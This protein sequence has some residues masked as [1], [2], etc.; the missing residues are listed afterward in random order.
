MP[1]YTPV[2]A[3]LAAALL[4]PTTAHAWGLVVPHPTR[5]GEPR[6]IDVTSDRVD[7]TVREGGTHQTHRQLD[8]MIGGAFFD[9][10]GEPVPVTLLV[11]DV[12]ATH[13]V[14][15]VTLDGAPIV[16]TPLDATELTAR[17]L[18]LAATRPTPA[19]AA[20]AGMPGHVADLTLAPGPHT[21]T[22]DATPAVAHD[23]AMLH[24]VV[25]LRDLDTACYTPSIDVHMTLVTRAPVATVFTPFHDRT[26]SRIEPGHVETTVR[27]SS[28]AQC[29]DLHAFVVSGDAAIESALLSYRAP[30]CD[31]AADDGTPGY[32]LI[33]GGTTVAEASDDTVAKD[34][35]LVIDTSGSMEGEKI[36]Q[37]RAA[38]LSILDHLGP[39]DRYDLVTFAGE[40][41]PFF[42]G[43]RDASDA[44]SLD[45]ARD[46][47]RGLTAE[48]STNIHDALLTALAGLG[49]GDTE[50]P[51]MLL[52]LTDGAATA[53]VTDSDQI[54]AAVD[55]ANEAG[56]RFHTF[57][58]GYGVNTYL[59]DE[60]AR[61]NDG[62]AHYITPGVDIEAALAAFYARVRAPVATHLRLGA[63]GVT[64]GDLLPADLPDLFVDG[65][66]LALGRYGDAAAAR[67]TID[68]DTRR[69]PRQFPVRGQFVRRGTA[70][71]FLPRLWASRL[72]GELLYAARQN[73]GDDVM[74]AQIR[75]LAER[76]GF[77]T[78]WT[79]FAVDEAGNVDHDYSNPTA[80]VSGSNAVHTSAGI[81][82]IAGNSNAGAYS[83]SGPGMA[84]MKNV[85]DRTFVRRAGYWHDTTVPAGIHDADEG[86]LD[87][88]FMDAQW[89]ALVAAA[90]ELREFLA[91][92]RN[93]VVAWQCLV[94][95]VTDP[96]SIDLDADELPAV[97]V[98]P[99][100]FLAG[101]AS[102]DVE[103]IPLPVTPGPIVPI[104]GDDATPWRPVD[105]VR[106]DD[107]GSGRVMSCRAAGD[108]S[109]APWF[110][111]AAL[112]LAG[113]RRVR[114]VV[115]R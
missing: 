31:A 11:P 56:I 47:V 60:L 115:L 29:H 92:G 42:G 37:V 22:I 35:S 49:V 106:G 23:G 83:A 94:L 38:L 18:D 91:V 84:A 79:S 6:C 66:L 95:R 102:P 5:E 58:V 48:G 70:A 36:A 80:D 46:L 67:L 55:A 4:A 65:E 105:E 41:H 45:R 2:A 107:D 34:L 24:V 68:A 110:V 13:T 63:E 96:E 16:L 17:A 20:I 28:G 113:L 62:S 75:A 53:G 57:G 112:S 21:L 101:V 104:D 14:P 25:P 43:L 85:L 19:L 40:V 103:L 71:S 100:T 59:L 50:R 3:A 39:T 111:L 90:P 33:A 93:V 30:A 76:H 10:A 114:R 54:L 99:E 27:T 74:V 98:L 87:V 61:R 69:G 26:L 86:V 88:R 109:I 64:V 77:V 82:D 89:R 44:A 8:F 7:V 81:N 12:A 52:F 97:D 78:Q 108:V 73:G 15:R 32:A 1:R 72:L 9:G 51:R